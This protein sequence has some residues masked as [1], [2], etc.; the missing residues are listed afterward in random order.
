MSVGGYTGTGLRLV[1]FAGSLRRDS[2]N[3]ALLVAAQQ[4]APAGMAIELVQI[5]QLPFYNA[6]VEKEGDPPSVAKFKADLREADGLLI[7]TPEYNAGIPG[8]L[9]NAI[10]WASRLPGRAPL[11]GK[12]VALMGAS[13]GQI[14]TARA[15]LHLRQL[16]AH[17]HAR[18]LPPPEL[19]V[20]K[21]HEKFDSHHRLTDEHTRG[22]L[23]TLLERFARWIHREQAAIAADRLGS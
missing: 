8:V 6:D 18:T 12:P 17:V 11:T 15:Q 7:A 9:T 23:I 20:A 13:P 14:G 22:V 5:G 10:D 19:L 1:G 3:R 21:A 4:V 2:F 16:L